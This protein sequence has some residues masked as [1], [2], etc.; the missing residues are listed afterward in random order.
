MLER[1]LKRYAAYFKGWCQAFGDHEDVQIDETGRYWLIAEDRL[2]LV[3]PRTFIRSLNREVLL[4]AKT[5]ALTFSQQGVE[6]GALN[7]PFTS[8][9]EKR[10]L[11]TIGDLVE[12]GPELHVFLTSHLIYESG[13][14]IMTFSS[15]KPLSIIYKEIGTMNIQLRV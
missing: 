7:I 2:G 4:N 11:D 15:K 3:L 5:P 14:R 12:T 1:E 6:I 13:S 9:R 8:R 10:V